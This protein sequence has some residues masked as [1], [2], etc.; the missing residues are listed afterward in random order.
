MLYN[1]YDIL[2]YSGAILSTISTFIIIIIYLK[3]L[4]DPI[5]LGLKLIFYLII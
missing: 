4:K 5:K 2:Q 1:I 3:Y